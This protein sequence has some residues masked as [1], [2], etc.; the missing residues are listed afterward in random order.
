MYSEA[1]DLNA[2]AI[3]NTVNPM[4]LTAR[5]NMVTFVASSLYFC[6]KRI[7]LFAVQRI[8]ERYFPI[9]KE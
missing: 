4:T 5:Q 3:L 1:N 7:E 2:S 6:A 8:M 9:Y